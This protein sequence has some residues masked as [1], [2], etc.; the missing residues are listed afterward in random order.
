MITKESG[1]GVGCSAAEL[2]GVRHILA[3]AAPCRGTGLE[4]QAASALRTIEAVMHEHGA[5]GSIVQQS[6][7]LKDIDDVETCRRILREFYGPQMPATSFVPQTPCEGQLLAIEAWG[8][9]RGHNGKTGVEI[10]RHGEHLVIARHSGVAWAHAADFWSDASSGGVYQRSLAAFEQM[11]RMLA[12]RRLRYEQVVRTWLYLGDIVGAEGETQR[13]KELNRARTDFYRP[14]AF[15]MGRTPPCCRP[16]VY[17]ASTGIGTCGRCIVMS[18]IALEISR[19]DVLVIPLENPQQTSAFDYGAHYSPRSPKFSRAMAVAAGDSATIFVSGTASITES[20]TRH[21]G[22][23]E[24]QTELTLDNIEAL[25]SPDNFR[26]HGASQLGA[27]LDDLALVRVYVKRQE[28][29]EKT[30]AVCR[31]RLGEL[32]AVYTVADVCRSELLVEIEGVG[33][34]R[35]RQ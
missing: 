4:E 33:F 13:Y 8:V 24:S 34:V 1:E 28:D 2:N 19:P 30:R 32:A 23:V 20:E 3:T 5:R 6:V 18:C 10:D 17:P 12:N 25:I 9:G 21:V 15:G 16:P 11:S 27:A 26:C 14:F 35:A 22:D 7:F 31:R 29:F